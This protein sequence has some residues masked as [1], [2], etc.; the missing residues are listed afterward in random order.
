MFADH[1]HVDVSRGRERPEVHVEVELEA[2]AQKQPPLDDPGGTSGVP[3]AEQ[4]GVQLPPLV[5]HAVGE[6]LAVAE[7]SA[8]PEVVVDG[9]QV[10]AGGGHDLERLGDD[11]RA[12]AVT[13]MTPTS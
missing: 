7:V 13:P 6:D 11:L 1:D 5:E 4:Q 8:A 3:T 9:I 10:H 2:H 12:D